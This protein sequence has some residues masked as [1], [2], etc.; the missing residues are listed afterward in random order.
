MLIYLIM[1]FNLAISFWAF[2][3]FQKGVDY[4]RFLFV[5]ALAAR[6]R[7]LEGF[8]LSQ[9][10]HADLG[11]LFFNM[12]TLWFFGPIVERYLGMHFLT[13][14]FAAGALANVAVFVFRRGNPNYKVLGASGAITG[15]LFAAIVLEPGM[16]ISLLILPIPVPAPI[17]AVLYI[18]LSTFLMSRGDVANVSHE[19]HVGGALAGLLLGGLLSP[20]GFR[21][22]LERIRD[23]V[24]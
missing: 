17:F 21:P 14:Y 18:A 7:N 6:G 4:Q 22:L 8:F 11:H 12:L 19:A 24:S 20:S 1:G 5:P 13:I 16:S 15:I 10:S 23:L 9:F 3:A 2:S